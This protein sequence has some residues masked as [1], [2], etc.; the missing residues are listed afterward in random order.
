MIGATQD[1]SAETRMAAPRIS[2]RHSDKQVVRHR[3]GVAMRARA[4]PAETRREYLKKDI[5][6][7]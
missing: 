5:V 7:R 4:S 2:S 6:E 1:A 3:R